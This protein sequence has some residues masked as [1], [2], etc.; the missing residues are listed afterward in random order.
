MTVKASALAT[1]VPSVVLFFKQHP[2]LIALG[3]SGELGFDEHGLWV[4]QGDAGER[5]FRDPQGTG[6]SAVVISADASWGSNQHNTA[7]F[8][9]LQVLIFSD[10]DRDAD[11][12]PV[13]LNQRTKAWKIYE[14][15]DDVLHDV[16]N[17]HHDFFGT[18]VISSSRHTNP[19]IQPVPDTAGLV[20]LMVRYEVQVP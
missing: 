20:R 19:G 11:N 1:L 9:L 15:V 16:S 2:G 12:Q 13:R 17:T 18:Q 3:K 10:A 7:Q 6:T 14:V 8:P 4:F 5:P